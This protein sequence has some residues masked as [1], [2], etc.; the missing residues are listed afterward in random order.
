MQEYLQLPLTKVETAHT[1]NAVL[2]G[3]LLTI[4]LALM[5]S[6]NA[7]IFCGSKVFEAKSLE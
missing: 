2:W 1:K 4:I 7:R 3:S 5:P 6:I